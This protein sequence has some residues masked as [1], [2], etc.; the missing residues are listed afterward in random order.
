[1]GREQRA[2]H[3]RWRWLYERGPVRRIWIAVR[4]FRTARSRSRLRGEFWRWV[5]GKG[6]LPKG[7]A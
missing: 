6:Q 2:N 5:S 3:R 4:F 7:I 1:M